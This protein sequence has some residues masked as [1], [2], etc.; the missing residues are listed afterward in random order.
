MGLHVKTSVDGHGFAAGLKKMEEDAEHFGKNLSEKI[1]G[2]FGEAVMGVIPGL[3]SS[4]AGVF[5]A[6]K[7]KESLKEFGEQA[8]RI[9]FGSIRLNVDPETFQRLDRVMKVT[10]ETAET[11]ATAFDKLAVSATKIEDG[12]DKTGELRQAFAELGVTTDEL[13][14]KDYRKI[15]FQIAE[16]LKDIEPSKEQIAALREVFGK[17][18]DNLLP[19]FK[20]G[21]D[22]DYATAGVL[23]EKELQGIKAVNDEWR[24]QGATTAGMWNTTKRAALEAAS[25]L[26]LMINPFRWAQNLG[27]PDEDGYH[28][29]FMAEEAKRLAEITAEKRKQAAAQEALH[30]ANRKSDE[31]DRKKAA[32]IDKETEA[33]KER[34]RIA[35]MTPEEKRLY[36]LDQIRQ[37]QGELD[38]GA[39]NSRADDATLRKKIAEAQHEISQLDKVKPKAVHEHLSHLGNQAIGGIMMGHD[40]LNEMAA[41]TRRSAEHLASI[42]KKMAARQP[43]GRTQHHDLP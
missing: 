39:G 31:A 32:T 27:T 40:R 24:K 18:G 8:E 23:D 3:T 13:A 6:E 17:Q 26:A 28:Q 20:L 1:S 14:S 41:H 42:D 4:I 43:S 19:A 34:N 21:F 11:A 16:G 22:S 37:M 30:E 5:A 7:I 12:R 33:L 29:K 9:E 35:A 36:L 25:G 10:G 15:F 2:H 38:Y